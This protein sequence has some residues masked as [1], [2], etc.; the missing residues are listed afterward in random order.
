MS[1]I[2]VNEISKQPLKSQ[3]ELLGIPLYRCELNYNSNVERS[4]SD[5]YESLGYMCAR[6]EG[7]PFLLTIKSCCLEFIYRVDDLARDYGA[8]ST[9]TEAL[10][11]RNKVH[12]PKLIETI[13]RSKSR[14]VL[15]MF[16]KIYDEQTVREAY[17]GLT[18]RFIKN[19]FKRFGKPSLASAAKIFASDPYTFR[20]G[21]PDL[22]LITPKSDIVLAEIK[23]TDKLHQNQIR[24]ISTMKCVIPHKFAVI[25]VTRSEC[26]NIPKV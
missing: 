5:K 10:F 2:D 3:C 21:W 11:T 26:D 17:P 25:Q 6:C 23:T 13:S 9:Y 20:N 4:L 1:Q 19:Y 24:T 18:S 12:N 8:L 15:K 16:N 7:G 14:H 22:T